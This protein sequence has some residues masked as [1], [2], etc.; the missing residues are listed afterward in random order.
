MVDKLKKISIYVG[1]FAVVGALGQHPLGA[2]TTEQ[3]TFLASSNVSSGSFQDINISNF[4]QN[5]LLLLAASNLEE[6]TPDNEVTEMTTDDGT[7]RYI[8]SFETE[9]LAVSAV[10]PETDTHPYSNR[11]ADVNS[12]PPKRRIPEPSALVGL[13]AIASLFGTQQ[14]LMKRN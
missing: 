6:I 11:W 14:L 10:Q 2:F 5:E 13:I 12:P 3:A 4:N 8:H 9:K 1:T 7:T